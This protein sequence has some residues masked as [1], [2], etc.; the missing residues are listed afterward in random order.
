MPMRSWGSSWST[1]IFIDS[2][3][4]GS[5][6]GLSIEPETSSRTTFRPS[7]DP[8]RWIACGEMHGERPAIDSVEDV[9]QAGT[10][11]GLRYSAGGENSAGSRS[12]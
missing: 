12:P 2:T 9:K 7:R 8:I 3:T 11:L 5:F 1:S 10:Y 4:H 6:S